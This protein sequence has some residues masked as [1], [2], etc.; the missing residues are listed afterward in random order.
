MASDIIIEKKI[1]DTKV[2]GDQLVMFLSLK[3]NK[4]HILQ[5]FETLE[6]LECIRVDQENFFRLRNIEVR[7]SK[8]KF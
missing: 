3:W 2:G 7:D 8:S 1:I 6:Y 4:R 5:D